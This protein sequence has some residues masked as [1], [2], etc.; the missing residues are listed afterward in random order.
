MS[1]PFLCPSVGHAGDVIGS[2]WYLVGGGNNTSGCT[3]MVALDL[4]PLGSSDNESEPLT[5]STVSHAEARSATVS[6]GLTVEAVPYARCLLSFGGY[7][8]KY[9]S[10]LQMF[11][12]GGQRCLKFCV[13]HVLH[14]IFVHMCADTLL[15]T[16][17]ELFVS[18]C[19]CCAATS[20][21]AGPSM[22]CC[23]PGAWLCCAFLSL[24]SHTHK[25][26][27]MHELLSS[28]CIQAPYSARDKA[29]L[30][31]IQQVGLVTGCFRLQ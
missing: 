5:W 16:V 17:Q 10:A 3:D 14:S 9:Q 28:F 24:I 29:K 1:T 21:W 26:Y 27:C 22:M 15:P 4:M 12:P 25:L 23:N 30:L 6:E 7:N 31:Y 13:D 11:K 18:A 2:H 20:C 8:G 19:L